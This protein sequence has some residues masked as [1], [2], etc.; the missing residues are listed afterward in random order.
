MRNTQVRNW[1]SLRLNVSQQQENSGKI[2]TTTI[3]VDYP[4]LP[5]KDGTEKVTLN[6]HNGDPDFKSINTYDDAGIGSD[7]DKAKQSLQ[8]ILFTVAKLRGYE[9]TVIGFWRNSA[10]DID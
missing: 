5:Y 9:D 8:A 7:A 6:V 1:H 3:E 2:L 4:Q 10:D